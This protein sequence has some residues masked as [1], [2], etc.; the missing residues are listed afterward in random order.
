M[1]R[2]TMTDVQRDKFLRVGGNRLQELGPTLYSLRRYQ[3][4]EHILDF[5]LEQKLTGQH[6]MRWVVEVHRGNI[7]SVAASALMGSP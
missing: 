1:P 5:L 2:R 6:L 7:H 4:F 3:Q